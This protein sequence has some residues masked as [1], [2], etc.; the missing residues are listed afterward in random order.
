MIK[1]IATYTLTVIGLLVIVGA[2]AGTKI[3]QFSAMA[4][5]GAAFVPPAEIVTAAPVT[6][7]VWENTLSATGSLAAVQG[8][9]VSTELASK[10]VAIA[11]ES[12]AKVKAGDLLIRQDT[13]TEEA[14]LGQFEA[15]LALSKLNLERNKDLLALKTVSQAEFDAADAQFR[16]ASSAVNNLRAVIAKKTIRAPFAGRLGLRL[17]NLGQSLREGDA[18][19]TLQTLDP[20]YVNFSLPQQRLPILA[21]GGKLRVSSDAVTDGAIEGT[22]TAIAPEVDIA[23]RNVRV[24]ATLA[25]TAEHYR[26]GMFAKVTVVLPATA[27]NLVI[28]ATA[29]LYAPY[30]DSVFVIDEKKNEK[31]GPM[32]KILRQQFIRLGIAKGDFVTVVTGLKAGEQVVTTGAFKLR[33][34]MAVTVD[35]TLAPKAELAPKPSEG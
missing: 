2:L 28:P 15:S 12:G 7:A 10:V 31:S 18:I 11:F 16:Q 17:V 5:A 8:V 20:I 35:N 26:P 32:E 13:S 34:G 6:E 27:A 21:V 3:L 23:T 33:P 25:N 24:Q 29:V 14:Q 4:A 9:T 1:K 30:G 19:V 22:I